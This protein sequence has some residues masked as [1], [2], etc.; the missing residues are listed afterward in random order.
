MLSKQNKERKHGMRSELTS[1]SKH[2]ENSADEAG[3][4]SFSVSD[5]LEDFDLRQTLNDIIVRSTSFHAF[6]D[7]LVRFRGY[8]H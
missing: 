3:L 1:T 6:R 2:P 5:G 4:A 8:L 7:A